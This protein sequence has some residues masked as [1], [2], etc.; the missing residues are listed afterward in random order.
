MLDRGVSKSGR[1]SSANALGS[2]TPVSGATLKIGTPRLDVSTVSPD[3]A[4]SMSLAY[5][6]TVRLT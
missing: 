3:W 4:I 2:D 1:G 6:T 5:T